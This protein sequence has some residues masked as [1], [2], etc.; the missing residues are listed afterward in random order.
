LPSYDPT[1]VGPSKQLRPKEPSLKRFFLVAV[2]AILVAAIVA[3][4]G[5]A[6]PGSNGPQRDGDHGHWYKRACDVPA[7]HVAACDAQVVT[8]SA[9]T[10]LVTN[11]TPPSGALTPAKL[12]GAY[13]LPTTAQSGTPTIA[14]VDA[15][16]D[17]N[18][19]ADLGAYDS[20]YG[21]PPCT[22]S[23][24]CFTKVNQTGG[25]TYP[26]ANA[27]W[28]LEIALD[29]ETAHQICQ[30][31]NILL[32]EATSNSDADLYA[33]ENEAAALGAT[34]ISNSWGGSE[35]SGETTDDS[36]FDH[37]N[38]FI[39]ASSGDSGYGVEYPAASPYV[40][41][42]GGTT[43]SVGTGNSW[44]G[45]TAWSGTGSGCSAY[46]PK[47]AWQ[48]DSGCTRRTVADVS[49]DADPNSGAAVYDSVTYQ[50]QSGWF[51]VGGTSLASPLIASVY[52]LT[53]ATAN[54]SYGS[55][56]YS[57]TLSLH[58]V[59]SGSNGSCGGSYLCTATGGYDGP[60]GL[61]TPAGLTAFTAATASPDYSLTATPTSQ[62]V[63]Q[64]GSASYA[65]TVTP[66]NGFT[67]T[68]T[69][70][71]TGLP[72]GASASF[73]PASVS[74]AGTHTS[75]MTVTT[76]SALTASSYGFSV[77]GNGPPN[78]SAP[79]TLVVQAAQTG[80]FGISVNPPSATIGR[81]STTQYTVTISR[82]NFNGAVSLSATD[83]S[84]GLSE[85]FS[86]N[87]TTSASSTLTV[88]ARNLGRGQHFT[89]TIRGASGSLSHSTTLTLST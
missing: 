51:Q 44:L 6:D 50:G 63:T 30:N 20:Q 38:V 17:P 9:G 55:I 26:N 29:V 86:P 67:G 2:S 69:L 52:A 47:P 78:H 34:A 3:A 74:G 58:D 41:A 36:A 62:T 76:T 84:S 37:P 75:T 83:N 88:R 64:G 5:G 4:G 25:T 31:C 46:E 45:E 87:P 24:G 54:G 81:S 10:P 28:S 16:D 18:I 53:G 33:A 59:M 89:V 23:N 14:I 8:D 61:G 43:L 49:A 66:S 72:G 27:G 42:V 73:N 32:V 39:T 57:H 22:T 82:Q 21:L 79:A 40:T 11:G 35:Y 7:A 71:T 48:T 56:P 68:V 77:N 80:D 1:D 60:T 12:H 15:F 13:S 85:W 19:E 70:G 65:V